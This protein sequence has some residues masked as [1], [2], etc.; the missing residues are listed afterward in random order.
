MR[1]FT[2]FTISMLIFLTIHLLTS[3]V[4]DTKYFQVGLSRYNFHAQQARCGRGDNRLLLIR[5]H[6]SARDVRMHTL[7]CARA[8]LLFYSEFL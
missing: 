8:C 6:S 1:V 7:F 2:R 3:L 4:I 5:N